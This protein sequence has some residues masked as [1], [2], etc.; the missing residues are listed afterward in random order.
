MFDSMLKSQSVWESR[1]KAGAG[2][3]QPVDGCQETSCEVLNRLELPAVQI[4]EED[5]NYHAVNIKR[6]R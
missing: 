4:I 1:H 6:F 3:R 2:E 5:V